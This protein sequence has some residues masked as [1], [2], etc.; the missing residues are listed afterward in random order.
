[1]AVNTKRRQGVAI[2]V[3]KDPSQ[4]ANDLEIIDKLETLLSR[5][6]TQAAAPTTSDDAQSGYEIGTIWIDTNAG[7]GY[8]LIDDS[9]GAASWKQITP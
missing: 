7:D 3:S 5:V 6:E 9:I 2:A 8:V 1:M 4:A